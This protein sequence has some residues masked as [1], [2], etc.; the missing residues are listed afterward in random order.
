LELTSP[1][2]NSAAS[3]ADVLTEYQTRYGMSIAVDFD[4]HPRPGGP[5]MDMGC[6]EH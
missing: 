4:N 3:Y 1:A 2:V 5:A 6:F